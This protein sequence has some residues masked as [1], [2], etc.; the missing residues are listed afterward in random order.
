MRS[1]SD[2]R[3]KVEEGRQGQ[4]EWISKTETLKPLGSL[5]GCVRREMGNEP[6]KAI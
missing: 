3:G 2:L 6:L 4:R 1:S 5:G